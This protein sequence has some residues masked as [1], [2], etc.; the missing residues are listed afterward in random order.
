VLP[1][2][3]ALLRAMVD[4]SAGGL[5][6]LDGNGRFA[7]VNA[8]AAQLL[9]VP[10]AELLGC[11]APFLLDGDGRTSWS[12]PGGRRRD[13]SYHLAPIP[14][15]H[16][17]WFDDVTDA[18]A[19]QERLTAITRAAS[20]V[21]D[22]ASLRA[23]LEAVAAEVVMTASIAAVQITAIDD[24]HDDVRLLGMAGFGHAPEFV[25]RLSACRRLGARVRFLEAFQTGK[26][27]VDLHRRPAI[28]A[29]PA[30][31]P[32]HEIMSRPDWDSF[33]AMPLIVRGRTLGVMNAYYAPGD[34]PGEAS[35]AFLEAMADHAAVAIDT[36]ALLDQT[37]SQAQLDE[38]RRLA[39]DLHDSVVQQ[40]FSMRMQAQALQARADG[41]SGL[42]DAAAELA[43][44]ARSALTDL[45]G[46][47][48]E[49][50]PLDLAERGLVDAVRAHAAG[51]EARTGLDVRID[52]PPDLEPTCGIDIQEDLY[53]I[54]QE[55]LHNVEKHAQATAVDVRFARDA[56][57][58]IVE[59]TDDGRGST[60]AEPGRERLGL[61]SMRERAQRW[62]GRLVA[63][64]G[65]GGGWAVRVTLAEGQR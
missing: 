16:V 34:D 50:R 43:A 10:V 53:R 18:V 45:R 64:P 49:L 54:V 21:A 42:R 13:L 57:R 19:Q 44:L 17:V 9:G 3:P 14:D 56:T 35:L 46:L 26:P 7:T 31:A 32:L 62:G 48:F 63:G 11:A 6:E 8:A 22:L 47:V 55:A 39:R 33:V 60:V 15:G 58:L 40:L 36:A 5:A 51:L 37:R 4:V 2:D 28:M 1:D 61:V 59:V 41:G 52:A 25:E 27:V 30:W 23:T 24:P 12:G 65:A 29:D 38:R 20:S